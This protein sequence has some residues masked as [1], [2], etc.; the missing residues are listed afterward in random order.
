MSEELLAEPAMS[1]RLRLWLEGGRPGP[2]IRD[3]LMVGDVDEERMRLLPASGTSLVFVEESQ[4]ETAKSLTTSTVVGY[5]GEFSTNGGEIGIGDSFV[6]QLEGY[7]T[8]PYVAI[9]CPTVFSLDEDADREAAAAD[10]DTAF[11]SGVFPRFLLTQ[12][13]TVLDQQFW[14][15]S[16]RLGTDPARLY[17]AEG[18]S[19]L[20]S[21]PAGGSVEV[22]GDSCRTSAPVAGEDN[23]RLL[24]D[25]PGIGRFFGAA[26]VL[27]AAQS[28][29]PAGVQ[30]AG[31][32]FRLVQGE[33]P[34]ERSRRDSV[35][36][37]V[38]EDA[39][40]LTDLSTGKLSKVPK[41]VA[42]VV[43]CVLSAA[44]PSQE[45]QARL[46][47]KLSG[48]DL[49]PAA[50]IRRS[51]E[52]QKL[53]EHLAIAPETETPGIPAVAVPVNPALTIVPVIVT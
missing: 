13:V 34:G 25:N 29:F 28:R 9:S 39:Y 12:L 30:V 38:A 19:E 11:A 22:S 43:E 47:L 6:L 26:K 3:A 53:F 20:L 7:A 2:G 27:R 50:Q 21:G 40:Y 18:G 33:T 37:L 36:V 42:E 8:A 14:Q 51:K 49:S 5:S 10:A 23:A 35:Y 44:E 16:G 45:L 48:K 46:G 31:F 4:V 52:L 15:N 41:D 24:A 1:E 32:G 17:V